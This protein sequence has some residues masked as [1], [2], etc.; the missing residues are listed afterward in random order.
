MTSGRKKS[1]VWLFTWE[2]AQFGVCSTEFALW[3]F[4]LF[5]NQVVHHILPAAMLF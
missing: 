3:V 1:S 5:R 4:L 2:L